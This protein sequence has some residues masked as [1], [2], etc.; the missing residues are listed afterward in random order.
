MG[1]CGGGGEGREEGKK[2][3]PL[4][5][6]SSFQQQNINTVIYNNKLINPSKFYA[7]TNFVFAKR[8]I[9][10]E[11]MV[12]DRRCLTRYILQVAIMRFKRIRSR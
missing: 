4:V 8:H 11:A 6:L 7:Q 3:K 10:Y 5:L 2:K 12:A 9:S 1:G